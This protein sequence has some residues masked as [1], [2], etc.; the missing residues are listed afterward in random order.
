MRTGFGA[1]LFAS[2]IAASAVAHAL[3]LATF[4]H[5]RVGTPTPP[6]PAEMA[7]VYDGPDP[8][9]AD[10]EL[11]IGMPQATGYATHDAPGDREQAAREAPQDQ[12][13]LSLDP[14]GTSL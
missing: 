8:R 4:S 14:V 12:P 13:S 5:V 1:T 10:R 9:P 7:V 6:T 2:A 3:V 11:D